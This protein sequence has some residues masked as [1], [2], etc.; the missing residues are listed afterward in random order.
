MRGA[1]LAEAGE[2]LG[3]GGVA[4]LRGLD[5]DRGEGPPLRPDDP[6]R[7]FEVVVG[8]DPHEVLDRPR[9][10]GRARHHSP[11]PRVPVRPGPGPVRRRRR[12]PEAVVAVPVVGAVELEHFLAPGE[13]PREAESEHHRLRPREGETDPV[14]P[15]DHAGEALREPDRK[16]VPDAHELHRAGRLALYRLDDRGVAVAED[17]GAAAA[18]VVD[19]AP[20]PAVDD[21][22]PAPLDRN[23]VRLRRVAMPA[24]HAARHAPLRR[25]QQLFGLV[26]RRRGR[27]HV[28]ARTQAA[29]GSR[30]CPRI[31]LAGRSGNRP[32]HHLSLR[33][34]RKTGSE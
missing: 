21:A 5:D 16:G 17:E 23:V 25:P 7:R 9:D 20:A 27:F 6:A 2:E 14:R 34:I 8:G 10:P 18:G 3:V 19:E 22:R 15:P 31:H 1:K 32:F 4:P 26:A 33:G 24:E 13:G 29:F 30:G 12:V 11:H 28:R